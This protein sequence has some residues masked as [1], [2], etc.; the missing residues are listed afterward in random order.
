MTK[1]HTDSGGMIAGYPNPTLSKIREAVKALFYQGISKEDSRFLKRF[2][3]INTHEITD[4]DFHNLSRYKVIRRF[5][6]GKSLKPQESEAIEVLAWL[7]NFRPRPF[8]NYI[9]L[10]AGQ[11]GLDGTD[12]KLSNE[13]EKVLLFLKELDA[14]S[15]SIDTKAF[16]TMFDQRIAKAFEASFNKWG[17]TQLEPLITSVIDDKFVEMEVRLKKLIRINKKMGLFGLVFLPTMTL[18]KLKEELAFDI[19]DA[20]GDF[21]NAAFVADD[22]G[23]IH[24]EDEDLDGILED[25]L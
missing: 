5:L 3:R 17:E 9:G 22:N 1:Y 23:D 25:L 24:I 12:T 18:E 21:F 6:V 4:A 20:I 16:A 2:L 14:L 7:V 8:S 19:L 11:A 13:I 10:D 15:N